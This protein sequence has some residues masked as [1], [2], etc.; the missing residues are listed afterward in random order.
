MYLGSRYWWQSDLIRPPDP[1]SPA[2]P[3]PL[4]PL[5]L[6]SLLQ[7]PE[8]PQNQ[9]DPQMKTQSHSSLSA[10]HHHFPQ[11]SS[12]LHPPIFRILPHPPLPHLPS[13]LNLQSP[14]VLGP[15]PCSSDEP[16]REHARATR[17]LLR[18]SPGIQ[19]C[20]RPAS[21]SAAWPGSRDSGTEKGVRT[22][23]VWMCLWMRVWSFLLV[24]SDPEGG[25]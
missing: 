13:P 8:P 21:C 25:G 9:R 22:L 18:S 3:Q 16:G 10:P 17:R 24:V 14:A 19:C 12:S 2:A 4:Q 6:L 7:P 15:V 11:S 5:L 1:E 20:W 23:V